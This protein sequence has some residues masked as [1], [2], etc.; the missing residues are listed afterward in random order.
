[1]DDNAPTILKKELSK[2]KSKSLIEQKISAY[3]LLAYAVKKELG[4][5][6]ELEKI[7]KDQRGKPFYPDFCISFSH[8]KDLV[9]VAFSKNNIGIDIEEV[10]ETKI[11]KDPERKLLFEGESVNGLESAAAL[12]TKK[13]A[14]YKYDD[15]IETFVPSKINT[16]KYSTITRKVVFDNKTFYVSLASGNTENAK[17]VQL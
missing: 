3:G 5:E 17:I 7:Q 9:A 2:I 12:W 6:I 14:I 16:N 4:F 15:N 10:K 13:E 8:T 1:M 11:F